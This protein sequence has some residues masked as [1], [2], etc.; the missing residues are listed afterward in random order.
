MN[1]RRWI[2]ST[3]RWCLLGP[4][5]LPLGVPIIMLGGILP[6]LTSLG[7]AAGCLLI[8]QRTAWPILLRLNMSLSLS[9]LGYAAAI[10][11]DVLI[12]H[13][14]GLDYGYS[15]RATVPEKDW[16]RY[17]S[18]GGDFEVLLPGTPEIL[19]EPYPGVRVKLSRPEVTYR[20]HYF[21]VGERDIR[22]KVGDA[23]FAVR[24]WPELVQEFERDYPQSELIDG[25]VRWSEVLPYSI[26]MIDSDRKRSHRVII[27]CQFNRFDDRVYCA[28]AITPYAEEL[29]YDV[30]LFFQSVRV[31]YRPR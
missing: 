14:N 17:K 25:G 27:D 21:T 1:T 20:V 7:L 31:R 30:K 2:D 3:P 26:R 13:A 15:K 12:P 18:P 9:V 11:Y 23:R 24:V 6:I 19:H 16:R 10:S 29:A 28:T 5:L 4:V 22:L 8:V